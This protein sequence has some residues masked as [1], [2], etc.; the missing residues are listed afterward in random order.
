[1]SKILNTSC[2]KELACKCTS[3]DKDA[4]ATIKKLTAENGKLQKA[5]AAANAKVDKV[6]KGAADKLAKANAKIAKLQ[7]TVANLKAKKK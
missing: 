7:E 4:Q 2:A 3:A 5:L 6:T 1:M